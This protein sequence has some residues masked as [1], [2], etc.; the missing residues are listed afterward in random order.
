MA[1]FYVVVPVLNEEDNIERFFTGLRHIA[2]GIPAGTTMCVVL[3]DD[4]ST[5]A[6]VSRAETHAGDLELHVLKHEVNR[7]PGAAFGT[8]FEFL[9]GRLSDDDYV[10]TIEGDN[11]SRYELVDKMLRRQTEEDYD[12]VFASP[13]MY[14]G[15]V[16]N[17]SSFRR[18]LSHMSNAFVK[19]ILQIHGLLTVS[20]FFRLYRGRILL[21]LQGVYGPRI[22]QRTGFESMLEL[23]LKMMYLGATISEVAMVLDTSQR[24]GKSKMKIARTIRGYFGVGLQKGKWASVATSH[25]YRH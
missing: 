11:T 18:F 6:T 4:G 5:D 12:A 23:T 25:G 24:A 22:L 1:A 10:L 15:G 3:V 9:A 2:T 19:E 7:G 13:Y 21:R 8:A 14:G 17:T 20:S 16:M